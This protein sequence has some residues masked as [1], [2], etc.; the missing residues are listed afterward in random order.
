M[1]NVAPIGTHQVLFKHDDRVHGWEL[2]RSDGTAATTNLVIDLMPGS[3]GG[4]YP[5]YETDAAVFDGRLYYANA[6]PGAGTE[7]IVTDGTGKGT[8]VVD[9][10]RGMNSSDPL[11]LM[12]TGDRIF[13]T[14]IDHVHGRELW[15]LKVAVF[16][17][18]FEAGDTSQWSDVLP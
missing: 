11:D 4:A 17:D 1:G 5:P 14:A 2:W 10:F 7:L 13:F 8:R 12:A 16:V 18:G 6:A 3:T 15:T 9:I